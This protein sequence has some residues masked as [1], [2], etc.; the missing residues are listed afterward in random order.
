MESPAGAILDCSRKSGPK[1]AILLLERT[2]AGPVK[3]LT[4]QWAT[5]IDAAFAF[6][7]LLAR[8]LPSLHSGLLLLVPTYPSLCL[9]QLT[10]DA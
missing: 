10:L 1:Y 5:T 2:T 8:R 7:C 4:M 3:K 9:L 6:A